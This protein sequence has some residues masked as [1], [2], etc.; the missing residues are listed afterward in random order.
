MDC[1]PVSMDISII[2][3]N[4]TWWSNFKAEF[5][6]DVMK[7]KCAFIGVLQEHFLLKD[8]TFKMNNI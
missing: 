2:S 7:Y 8:N 5:L 3:Y 4:S 6:M 1:T